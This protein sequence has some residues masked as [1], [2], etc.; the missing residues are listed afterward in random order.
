MGLLVTMLAGALALLGVLAHYRDEIAT[1]F[2]P[3][4]LI[5]Q[6]NLSSSKVPTAPPPYS[7]K[8]TSSVTWGY[9]SASTAD[10]GAHSSPTVPR[11]NYSF[12]YP[13]DV[14][15]AYVDDVGSPKHRVRNTSRLGATFLAYAWLTHLTAFASDT[16]LIGTVRTTNAVLD[17]RT[18]RLTE[19]IDFETRFSRLDYRVRLDPDWVMTFSC[20]FDRSDLSR[21]CAQIA[22]TFKF[23]ARASD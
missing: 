23:N 21:L 16:S 12:G 17:G 5:S 11:V 3:S 14:I 8:A 10:D 9:V 13:S 18:A 1:N 4:P 6:D 20:L 22:S 19:G 15:E 2:R 7:P